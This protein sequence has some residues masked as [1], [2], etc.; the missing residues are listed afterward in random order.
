MTTKR[1]FWSQFKT[2]SS[3]ASNSAGQL[4][5]LAMLILRW[6]VAVSVVVA[7]VPAAVYV[8]A[9]VFVFVAAVVVADVV[10]WL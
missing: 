7:V 4:G 2:L 10:V 5:N 6:P 8:A 3:N 9:V 1:T